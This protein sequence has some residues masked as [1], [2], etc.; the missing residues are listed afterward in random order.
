MNPKPMNLKSM[1][2]YILKDDKIES[3]TGVDTEIGY[4]FRKVRKNQFQN[5]T[6]IYVYSNTHEDTFPVLQRSVYVERGDYH[7][8]KPLVFNPYVSNKENIK[9]LKAELKKLEIGYDDYVFIVKN[10]NIIKSLRFNDFGYG[11]GNALAPCQFV[12]FV[13]YLSGYEYLDWPQQLKKYGNVSTHEGLPMANSWTHVYKYID[14]ES[15]IEFQRFMNSNMKIKGM[16]PEVVTKAL[17]YYTKWQA[18]RHAIKLS[19]YL[20]NKTVS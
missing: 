17:D 8:S 10:E 3:Y 19:Q 14:T 18:L 9:I 16:K 4:V 7:T 2:K 11:T 20:K 15:G 5:E 1:L 13:R 6:G 12:E